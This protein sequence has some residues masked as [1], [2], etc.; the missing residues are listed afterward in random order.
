[1]QPSPDARSGNPAR[2][3]CCCGHPPHGEER[4]KALV[5][6]PPTT[7]NMTACGCIGKGRRLFQAATNYAAALPPD[8]LQASPEAVSRFFDREM[9]AAVFG[10]MQQI[11]RSFE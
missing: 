11:E 10:D 3:R 7:R 5:E 4:C 2:Q 9:R 1:M 6:Y 8:P